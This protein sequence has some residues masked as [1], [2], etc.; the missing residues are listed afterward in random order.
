[1]KIY[2]VFCLVA[3]ALLSGCSNE[4]ISG[5][6]P[7]EV[8]ASEAHPEVLAREALPSARRA[9]PSARRASS[10]EA[11]YDIGGFY[12]NDLEEKGQ[13][14]HNTEE[15]S[16]IEENRFMSV[17]TNP[18]ST[19]SADVDTASYSNVRRLIL[20]GQLPTRDAVRIEEM[21]NYFNYDYQAPDGN[22][23]FNVQTEIAPCPWNKDTKLMLIGLNAK[24]IEADNLPPSNFVFLIDV[25]GSMED[26]HKLPLVK[27]AFSML[28]DNL[29]KKDKISIVTYAGNDKIVLDGSNNKQE[30]MD[31]I[32]NLQ[33]SGSTHGSSGII[34]A[35][36]LAKNHFIKDGNN[37]VILATDGDLNVGMTSESDL[38]TLIEERRDTGVYLS[39]LGF[40][41]GNYKDNKME[42][43]SQNGNGNYYYID[44]KLE[45]RKVLV[46]EMGGTLHTI[47]EDV[48]I[49]VEF[50]P[51][52]IKGYRLIG[53]ENRMLRAED[54]DDDTKDA[55]EIG[56]GH[57]VTVLYEIVPLDSPMKIDEV[58]LKYQNKKSIASD[59]W[60]TISLRYKDPGQ[61][62]SKLITHTVDGTHA[63]E[64]FSENIKL[65]SSVAE[66]G[67]LLRD[68]QHKGN[69]SYEM[70]LERLKT[71]ETLLDDEYKSEFLVLVQKM[72]DLNK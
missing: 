5:E 25:S 14:I 31:A 53:Y 47:A 37:R 1:M 11:S 2:Y 55:G 29:G 52:F 24:D 54:F 32:N 62:E 70:V 8:L 23:P 4:D 27:K 49:Q 42:T 65:A 68:S 26:N 69:S 28:V 56:A 59:D 45:A 40:G 35:Y 20:D 10:R 60:L 33:A 48:K 43:L 18:L 22:I 71:I 61:D 36:D 16:A 3:F 34:T 46:K 66:V 13:I 72:Q 50:N 7:P 9:S 12:A 41:S 64:T 44:S 17:Q 57:Q 51:E 30:I 6:A 19:F 39:T 15:Y 63:K 58:D 67:M 38:K 21:I